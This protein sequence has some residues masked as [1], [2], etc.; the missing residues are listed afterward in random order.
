[1]NNLECV[2]PVLCRLRPW[3]YGWAVAHACGRCSDLGEGGS[4][5]PVD[6]ALA[7][8]VGGLLVGYS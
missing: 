6:D 5:R 7:N 3:A 8:L 4:S 1:M 2:D